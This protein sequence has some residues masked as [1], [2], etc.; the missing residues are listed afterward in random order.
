MPKTAMAKGSHAVIGTGRSNCT[1]GSM[2]RAATRLQPIARPSGIATSVARPNPCST[3]REEYAT[4]SSQVPEYG[5]SDSFPAPLP[6]IQVC[7]DCSTCLG[8]GTVPSVTQCSS[9]PKCHNATSAA[10]SN[11]NQGAA[12]R[13]F[14]R[15]VFPAVLLLQ[16]ELLG[17]FSRGARE[18]VVVVVLR[19]LARHI[20][21]DDAV[22]GQELGDAL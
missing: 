8:E 14:M 4:L 16:P 22:V 15:G 19:H 3:R 2:T 17:A 20:A 11:R 10:G 9:T 1:V 12:N 6:K 21:R 18:E 13:G 5:L 7:H